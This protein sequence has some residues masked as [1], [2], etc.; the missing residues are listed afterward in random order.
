MSEKIARV[1]LSRFL[2]EY[3]DN[4]DSDQITVGVTTIYL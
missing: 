3:L 1:I 4:M 2:G